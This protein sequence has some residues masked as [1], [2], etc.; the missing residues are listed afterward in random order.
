MSSS[1]VFVVGRAE[2]LKE[3]EEEKEEVEEDDT[4]IFILMFP[5][6]SIEHPGFN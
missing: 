3:E 4:I 6:R 5:V 1:F 2:K